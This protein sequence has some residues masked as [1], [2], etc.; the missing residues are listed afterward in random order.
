LEDS[1]ELA[2]LREPLQ[3]ASEELRHLTNLAD[4]FADLAK[5]PPPAL[6]KT[7]LNDLIRSV[8]DLYREET[9][10]FAFSLELPPTTCYAEIDQTYFREALHNLLKNAMEAS[11]PGGRILL[12]M[13]H[14]RDG[15][16]F[17]VQDFGKG[18][19]AEVIQSAR[20]PYFTTREKGSGLGLAVV[21]KITSE[22]GGQLLIE[23]QE[24]QGTMTTIFVPTKGSEDHAGEDSD[25]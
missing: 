8:A 3:A 10:S 17:I 1:P 13:S 15:F 14:D 22:M 20:M 16:R 6:Q 9:A 18:M 4:R 11:D 7:N 21:D 25:C 19:S 12:K 23:S 2:R 24:G 5:L